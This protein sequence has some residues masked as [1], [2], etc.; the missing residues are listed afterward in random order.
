MARQLLFSTW[1]EM[2][3]GHL[4]G[5][6]DDFIAS[7]AAKAVKEVDYHHDHARM[8]VLRLGDGTAESRSRMA[9]AL[10]TE[11]PYVDELFD[12]A[13]FAEGVAAF[14]EKRAATFSGR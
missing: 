14:R 7:V 13:D 10:E 5:S 3:F 12:T 8:W 2:L 4:E 1:Q 9:T 6:S 11:W